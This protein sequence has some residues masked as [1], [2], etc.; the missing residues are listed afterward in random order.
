MD[1]LI[2]P[3]MGNCSDWIPPSLAHLQ[4]EAKSRPQLSATLSI[5]A[6]KGLTQTLSWLLKTPRRSTLTTTQKSKKNQSLSS[7]RACCPTESTLWSKYKIT[8]KN[9][10][11]KLCL[12]NHKT[13]GYLRWIG[14]PTPRILLTNNCSLFRTCKWSMESIKVSRS[15]LNNPKSTLTTS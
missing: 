2:H 12:L 13:S 6:N 7:T 9:P 8:A 4:S 15:Q 11:R 14:L 3:S 5:E 1:K 10:A